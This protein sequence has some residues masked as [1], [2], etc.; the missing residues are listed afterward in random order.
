MRANASVA[1]DAASFTRSATETRGDEARHVRCGELPQG[2][3]HTVTSRFF[4]VN[5]PAHAHG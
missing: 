4:N 2:D 3:P 5:D 1:M